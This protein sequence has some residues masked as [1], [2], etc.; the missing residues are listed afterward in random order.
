VDRGWRIGFLEPTDRE[1]RRRRRPGSVCSFGAGEMFKTQ[2]GWP[3]G[4]TPELLWAFVRV[5]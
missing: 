2:I 1:L 3:G 4:G 5:G